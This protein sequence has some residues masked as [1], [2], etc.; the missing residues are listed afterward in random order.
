MHPSVPP[1]TNPSV[2]PVR[3]DEVA[4]FLALA[5]VYNV[6]STTRHDSI[7]PEADDFVA[8]SWMRA[9][10]LPD[11]SGARNPGGHR[12]PVVRDQVQLPPAGRDEAANN[13][14]D[15]LVETRGSNAVSS[16][17]ILGTDADVG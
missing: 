15:A 6:V 1:K 17:Q 13:Q 16:T 11:T 10:V 14:I 7:F 3:P 9:S 5:S 2:P 12:H 8:R 4:E